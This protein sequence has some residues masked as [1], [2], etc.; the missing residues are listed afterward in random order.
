MSNKLLKN[1][2]WLIPV[3]D[4]LDLEEYN[5]LSSQFT[6]EAINGSISKWKLKAYFNCEVFFSIST[7]SLQF[8]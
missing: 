7:I 6:I 4:K 2:D 8:S 1:V 5:L 3:P